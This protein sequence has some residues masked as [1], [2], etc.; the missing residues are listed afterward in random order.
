MGGE[1]SAADVNVDADQVLPIKYIGPP[2]E[3]QTPAHNR[4]VAAR[5][6]PSPQTPFPLSAGPHPRPESEAD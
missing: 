4:I 5:R 3:V 1:N 6:P 2:L